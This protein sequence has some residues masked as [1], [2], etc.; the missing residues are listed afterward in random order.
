MQVNEP[1]GG[2]LEVVEIIGMVK[3]AVVILKS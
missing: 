3:S 2:S 1:V